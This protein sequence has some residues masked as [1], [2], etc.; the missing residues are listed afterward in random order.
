MYYHRNNTT[1]LEDPHA[2]NNNLEDPDE[3]KQ[4]RNRF[5]EI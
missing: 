3:K 4:R 2:K 5:N 1:N